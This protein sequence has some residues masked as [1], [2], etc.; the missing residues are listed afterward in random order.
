MGK[1]YLVRSSTLV[2]TRVTRYIP[3]KEH[4]IDVLYWEGSLPSP[5]LTVV[6]LIS[7]ITVT[8]TALADDQNEILFSQGEILIIFEKSGRWWEAKNNGWYFW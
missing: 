2:K 3:Q 1:I 7:N 5:F 8:G 4:C 6:M